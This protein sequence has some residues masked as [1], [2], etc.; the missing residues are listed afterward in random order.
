MS[1]ESIELRQLRYFQVVADEL[2]FGRAAERLGIAQPA[3][4]Q[5][6]RNLEI[7]TGVPLLTRTSRRVALTEAGSTLL[8]R[9]RILLPQ[10]DTAMAE[11]QRI[12][13]GLQGQFRLGYVGYVGRE[14]VTE[15]MRRFRERFPAVAI[16][17]RRLTLAEQ[18]MVLHRREVDAS[19]VR[20][21]TDDRA[22]SLEPVLEET[23]VVA[24]PHGHRLAERRT[25]CIGDLADDRLLRLGGVPSRYADWWAVDP[26][27]DGTKILYG[28]EVSDYD[29]ALDHVRHGTGIHLTS[30]S[31]GWGYGRPGVVF[32]PVTDVP[33][34]ILALAWR[35]NAWSPWIDGLV[36]LAR[37]LRQQDQA[38][39]PALMEV[40]ACN[41]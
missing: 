33:P 16:D 37:D 7:A 35:A 19:V 11:A 30:A 39:L 8:A 40:D 4:S 14:R 9:A 29:E 3:L 26:R 22:L 24:L 2:H 6:I 21:P 32:V 25:V 38:G 15:L 10:L 28:P 1:L 34:S 31:A 18:T 23:R 36:S 12:G 17:L 41:S 20:L 5:A 27:P 13:E